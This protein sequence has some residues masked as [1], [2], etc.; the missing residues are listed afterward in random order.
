MASYDKD[1][2]GFISYDEYKDTTFG[3]KYGELVA[4]VAVPYGFV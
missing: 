1:G 2:D 3:K 4:P